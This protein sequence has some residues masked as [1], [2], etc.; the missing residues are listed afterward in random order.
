VF[1]LVGA[2]LAAS[3][4]VAAQPSEQ[5]AA[6]E[7][8]FVEAREL[9]AREDF[10]HACPKFEASLRLD[11]ALGTRLNLADCYERLGKWTSA[12]AAFRA[13]ADTARG[14][15]D[16]RAAFA[17]ERAQALEQKLPRL[18]IRVAAGQPADVAVRRD[19]VIVDPALLGTAIVIDPGAH[20]LTATAAGYTERV[21]EVTAVDGKSIEVTLELAPIDRPVV[22]ATDPG[23][24]RRHVAIGLG[25]GG[26]GTAVVGLAFGLSARSVSNEAYANGSCNHTPSS[27]TPEGSTRIASAHRRA[28]IANVT[29]GVGLGLVVAATVLYLTAPVV[30]IA[31][32]HEVGLAFAGTF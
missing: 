27:C 24:R 29:T 16:D 10:A 30:P 32:D 9:A 4:P 3:T 21:V 2:A 23:R 15:N 11:P 13:A 17:A 1:T 31:N 8:L 28:T 20:R 14:A 25:I 19:D 6:A 12:W 26:A 18:V 5:L 7:Q 22:A